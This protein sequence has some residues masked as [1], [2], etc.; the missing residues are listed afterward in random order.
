MEKD[1][2]AYTQIAKLEQFISLI[3]EYIPTA[4]ILWLNNYKKNVNDAIAKYRIEN[5]TEEPKLINLRRRI[6][7]EIKKRELYIG[8]T[9]TPNPIV[10]NSYY[11]TKI[12]ESFSPGTLTQKDG[13]SPPE[14]AKEYE[15]ILSTKEAGFIIDGIGSYVK[16]YATTKNNKKMTLTED[17]K[18]YV[19]VDSFDNF[20]KRADVTG[21]NRKRVKDALFPK[22]GLAGLLENI[23]LI[24]PDKKNGKQMFIEMR[25]VSARL[26]GIEL[27]PN[28]LPD[29]STDRKIIFFE[30]DVRASLYDFLEHR[31]G[32]KKTKTINPGYQMVPIAL[33]AKIDRSLSFMGAVLKKYDPVLSQH[34]KTGGV[35]KYRKAT[36]YIINKWNTGSPSR[37]KDMVVTWKEL[38]EGEILPAYTKNKEK[39]K[40]DMDVLS[41]FI[42]NFNDSVKVLQGCLNIYM[43][44]KKLTIV[45][46]LEAKK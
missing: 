7:R 16:D 28:Q 21:D 8:T 9:P 26:K 42:K 11:N 36:L 1:G 17:E 46:E 19:I 39:R 5:Q 10:R 33:T 37:K 20:C 40:L 6:Q 13:L 27:R 34:Y 45:F 18:Y 35:V 22:P 2:R 12:L 44:F 30:M 3:E 4:D 14:L 32:G 23:T 38:N 41:R 15:K 43:D 25:F 24:I 31:D 29:N